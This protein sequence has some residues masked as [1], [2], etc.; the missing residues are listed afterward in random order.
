MQKLL[1]LLLTAVMTALALQSCIEDGVTTSP[2]A[3]PRFS[4][5]TLD[6]GTPF[7]ETA[8]PTYAFK[9]YNN[10]DKVLNISSIT[11]RDGGKGIFRM[12]VDGFSGSSFNNIEI[13]PNDSIYVFI[14]ATV[15]PTGQRLPLHVEDHLDFVTNGVTSTVVLTAAG[16]DVTRL[17]GVTVENEMTLNDELP[18]QIFD[19]LVVAPGA[20]LRVGPGASLHFH[21]KSFLRVYGRLVI[22]GTAEKPVNMTGDRTDNVV[23][24]I[25]FDLMASQWRGVEFMPG[26][27]SSRVSHAVI[28]NTVNG[29]IVDSLGVGDDSP[30]ITFVNSR[31][32]NS[33]HYVLEN[34]HSRVELIGC[35]LADASQGVVYLRGGVTTVNHSTIANYYLFTALGGAAV[36]LD[37]ID[38]DS[39]DGSGLPY[40]RVAMANTIIY[41]NGIDMS[42][43]DLTG[44]EVTLTSCLLKSAGSDDDNFISCLWDTDPLYYTVRE[45]YIFD[46]RLRDDSPAAEAGDGALTLPAAAVDFYGIPRPSMA[47]SL[48]A[49]Q[50]VPG[51]GE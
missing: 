50:F 31:L 45:D 13:R 12:N 5:D 43:G 42:H 49:Y 1:Y 34:H 41:G 16:Q 38:G 26:C 9:V 27:G 40:G 44:T 17:R 14:E 24:D 20:T 7:T 22:E 46:Y 48:G 30:V 8:T 35:E 19:S 29:V 47:P 11:F 33:A 4:V 37:H 15:P 3:Q 28:R 25:P 6:L 51:L 10:N 2:S 39:D 36:Q 21:D 32:R 18:Y 23:S